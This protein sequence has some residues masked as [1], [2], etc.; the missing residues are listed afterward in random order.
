MPTTVIQKIQIAIAN[1]G[2]RVKCAELEA[3]GTYEENRV[4][5]KNPAAKDTT[6]KKTPRILKKNL[7]F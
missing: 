4:T 5:K 2:G 7:I 1:R 3:D 6:P